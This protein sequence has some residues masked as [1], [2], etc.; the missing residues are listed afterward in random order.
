MSDGKHS[1][2]A[3]GALK[4]GI[5]IGILATNCRSDLPAVLIF[6]LFLNVTASAA[7]NRTSDRSLAQSCS[8]KWARE[9]LAHL[10]LEEKVG[11][12]L[13]VRYFADYES[14]EAAPYQGLR[15]QLQRYHIG[16]V[17][18]GL[19]QRGPSFLKVSAAQAAK[20]ANQIQADS[21]L[22]VLIGADLER[23]LASRLEDVPSFAYQMAFGASGDPHDSYTLGLMTAREARAVGFHWAFAPVADVNTNPENPDIN[24]RSFGDN[25]S[26]VGELVASFVEGAHAGGLLV[27][28]KHFP[29]QGNAESDSHVTVPSLGLDRNHLQNVEFPPFR[30]AIEAGVDAIMVE[31]ARVPVLDLDPSRV[32]TT[33]PKII[34]GVLKGELGFKGLVVTDG[35]EMHGLLDLYGGETKNATSRAAID[36]VRAGNDVITLPKDLDAAFNAIVNAVRT[37]DISERRIDESVLKILEAK[38]SVGLNKRRFVDANRANKAVNNSGDLA[39]AQLSADKAVTLVRNNGKVLPLSRSNSKSDSRHAVFVV[40]KRNVSTDSGKA[41]QSAVLER[42]PDAQF[43]FIDPS[44]AYEFMPKVMDA[45]STA[46]RIVIAT[47]VDFASV[48]EVIVDNTVS[49]S[50]GL[51]GPAEKLMTQILATGSSK[52]GVIAIGSPYIIENFPAIETYLCTYSTSTTSEISAVKAIFGEIETKGKLPVVLPGIADRGLSLNWADTKN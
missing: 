10:S 13:Q 7:P 28:A 22:P 47:F 9:T 29:G 1:G 4:H 51:I 35:L 31:H 11:Q 2:A 34:E 14:F 40:F 52:V 24:M 3:I 48:R 12:M 8:C 42:L 44:I 19:H 50:F 36:A 26:L 39:F 33:S 49:K 37:G 6:V 45:V 15:N 41:F 43:F 25:P 23:G 18:L 16:S 17:V 30:R 21:K 27:T 20:V 5:G 38:E 46:D 32:A